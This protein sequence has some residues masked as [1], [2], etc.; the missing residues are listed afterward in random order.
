MR[1]AVLVRMPM[2]PPSSPRSELSNPKSNPKPVSG[3]DHGLAPSE[4]KRPSSSTF[5]L[6]LTVENEAIPIPALEVGLADV[7]VS[8]GGGGGVR[9]EVGAFHEK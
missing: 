6:S 1:V 8:P 2:P 5:S 4:E 9:G 3:S 7:V